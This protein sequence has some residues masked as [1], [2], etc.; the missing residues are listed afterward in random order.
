[1][2]GCNWCDVVW[3]LQ[4][5]LLP[6]NVAVLHGGA[7][8]LGGFNLEELSRSLGYTVHYLDGISQQRK[9]GFQLVG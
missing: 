9:D 1:M 8:L 7:W 5:E 2:V 3:A 4:G 6:Q